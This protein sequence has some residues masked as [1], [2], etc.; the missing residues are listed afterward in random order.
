MEEK[1]Q[2][3]LTEEFQVVNVRGMKETEDHYRRERDS[4]YG[5]RQDPLVD[6]ARF[7]TRNQDTCIA[8]KHLSKSIY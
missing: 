2:N 3:F 5:Y 8:S 1:G 7:K 4:N 6:A